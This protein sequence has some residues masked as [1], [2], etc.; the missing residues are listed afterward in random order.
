[1]TNFAP[2]SCRLF[3]FDL[4]GTLIDSKADITN[5]VNLVLA[6]LDLPPLPVSRI[7]DFVGKGV[8][9]LLE[10]VLMEIHHRE[11]EE[12][13]VQQ[14]IEFFREEY[15]KH[16]L[17]N[18]CLCRNVAETL[19]RLSWADLAVVSN[20]P[21]R[22]SRPILE[23][24]EIADRFIAILGEETTHAYKPDPAPLK[25][26]MEFCGAVPSETVMVGDSSIDIEAGKAAGV[27][28]C[29]VTGGY[30]SREQL[31]AAAPDLIIDNLLELS[32]RFHNGVES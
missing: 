4:D 10:R 7:L 32:S 6:K 12:G 25:V 20:K 5:S 27:T 8:K 17:D 26:A 19:N 1:M 29:A 13:I 3:L 18:T 22:Y 28:T 30:H 15:G 24:L 21:E 11:P 16:L 23:G 31:L 2:R 9:K 14:G